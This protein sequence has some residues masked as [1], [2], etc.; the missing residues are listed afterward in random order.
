M[1]IP[2]AVLLVL[3]A[4]VIVMLEV[5]LLEDFNL[6]NAVPLSSA[7]ANVQSTSQ[8]LQSL[9]AKVQELEQQVSSLNTRLAQ[10]PQVR[11]L[12]TSMPTPTRANTESVLVVHVAR[13]NVRSGPG[14]SYDIIG[15]VQEGQIIEGPF[16]AGIDESIP[17]VFWRASSTKVSTQ[18]A[19]Q[20]W[21]EDAIVW[22][23]SALA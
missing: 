13:G 16:S 10:V 8:R 4:L 22:L 23:V 6:T 19:A 18:E 3:A 11:P 5:P 7:V 12:P 2:V 15:A 20:R 1:L 17:V 21:Y 9:E 14:I